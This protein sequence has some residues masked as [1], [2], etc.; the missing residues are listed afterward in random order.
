MK[1]VISLIFHS[2][3]NDKIKFLVIFYLF[4]FQKS[5]RESKLVDPNTN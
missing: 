4:I 2:K 1:L 5:I 3:I